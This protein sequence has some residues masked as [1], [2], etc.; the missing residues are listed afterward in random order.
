MRSQLILSCL[1]LTACCPT[2]TPHRDLLRMENLEEDTF[3]IDRTPVPTKPLKYHE[4]VELSLEQNLD[5]K[6]KEQ[7]WRIKQEIATSATWKILPS[8]ILT[9]EQYGRN[10]NTGSSSQSLTNQPPAPP[11]ISSEQHDLTYDLTYTW[12]LLDFGLA[13]GRARQD[14][15]KELMAELEYRRVKQNLILEVT[16]SYW[17][18]QLAQRGVERSQDLI[19]RINGYQEKLRHFSENS[20]IPATPSL[21]MDAQL[22]KLKLQLQDFH[23]DFVTAKVQ[24]A[25]FM[26]LKDSDSFELVRVDMLDPTV[27]DLNWE[28][29]Q[30]IALVNRPETYNR[31]LEEKVFTEEIRNQALLMAPSVGLYGATKYDSNKFLLFN[32]WLQAGLRVTYNLF[33]IPAAYYDMKTAEEQ[34]ALVVKNRVALSLG[35]ITQL[36]LAILLYLD[37]N[38]NYQIA[39]EYANAQKKL[40]SQAQTIEKVGEYH[41]GDVLGYRSDAFLAEMTAFEKYGDLMTSVETINNTLGLPLHYQ[42]RDDL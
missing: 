18:A 2:A 1:F 21:K 4:V 35:I 13:Y 31:D 7:E 36:Q 20:T 33:N 27:L 16:K 15:N 19:E 25:Q 41:E 40:L 23:H 38:E 32:K 10:R 6:V 17:K 22:S 24:L 37:A 11:S 5:L 30:D 14:A 12:N 29:M 3:E 26:G 28:K 42:V 34:R 8:L 9:S 39:K